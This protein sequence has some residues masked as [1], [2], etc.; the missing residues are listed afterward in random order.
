MKASRSWSCER[1]LPLHEKD[2]ARAPYVC[3][4]AP[5]A[6]GFEFDFLDFFAENAEYRLEWKERGSDE[7]FSE[8]LADFSGRVTGLRSDR[9]SDLHEKC[10]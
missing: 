4:I 3:R 9:S 1:Y 5:L 2:R 6:D 7:T 10:Q 8:P